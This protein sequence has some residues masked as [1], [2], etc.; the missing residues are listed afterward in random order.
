MSNNKYPKPIKVRKPKIVNAPQI[1]HCDLQ[2]IISR[3]RSNTDNS[4]LE[5]PI[6]LQLLLKNSEEFVNREGVFRTSAAK[7]KVKGIFL[8]TGCLYLLF[9]P[10]APVAQK[11]ADE[12]VFRRFRGERVEFC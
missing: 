11:V 4:E 8:N 5:I 3:D 9:N 2:T 12:V 10:Q 1:F 6:V 7:K